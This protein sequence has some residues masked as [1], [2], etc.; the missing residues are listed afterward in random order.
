MAG[1]GAPSPLENVCAVVQTQGVHEPLIEYRLEFDGVDT[2]VLELEGD[3]PPIVLFHGYADSA[4]T[5]RLALDRLGRTGRRALA[6]DLPGFGTAARLARDEGVLPQLDRFG[7]AVVRHVAAEQGPVVVA[8]NSLGG[9]LTLRLAQDPDLPIAAAVPVAP[10][11]FDHPVWFRAIEGDRIVRA[12]LRAP[13]PGPLFRAGVGEAFRQLAFAR[14][15]D[16]EA[17]VVAAFGRHLGTQRDVRRI[18]A[19]GSRMLPELA[20]PFRLEEIEVP[21]L[22]V[23]GDRDRMV[24]HSGARHVLDALPDTRYELLEGIGHCPQVEAPDRFVALLL[25]FVPARAAA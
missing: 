14:P 15:R 12:L 5:W 13:L 11:G 17:G 18:L 10:A 22:L 19:T 3:G 6:V 9:C 8:G 2:R 7:A 24:S 20:M 23:W 1:G 21:V 4:D 25:E 16:I